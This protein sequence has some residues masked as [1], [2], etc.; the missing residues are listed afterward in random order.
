MNLSLANLAITFGSLVNIVVQFAVGGAD[1]RLA[2]FMVMGT[3]AVL[4]TI[5]VLPF[6]KKWNSDMKMLEARKQQMNA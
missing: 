6:S 3:L 2:V 1:N 5:N 4:A